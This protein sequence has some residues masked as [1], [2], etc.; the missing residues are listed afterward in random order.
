MKAPLGLIGNPRENRE[1]TRR[2]EPEQ[3]RFSMGKTVVTFTGY[4]YE[5]L[6]ARHDDVWTAR[7]LELT[8]ILIDGPYVESLRDLEL[9]FRGSS[10]QRVLEREDRQALAAALRHT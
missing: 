6:L 10:N 1:W 9:R 5:A 4:T 2:R 3:R 8:D 7:L